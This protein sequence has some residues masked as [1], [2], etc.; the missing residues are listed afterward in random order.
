[1]KTFIL[2]ALVMCSFAANSLLNKAAV[3]VGGMG[4]VGFA[5]VRLIAGA[6]TLSLI[7]LWRDKALRPPRPDYFMIGF[8]SLYMIA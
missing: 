6:L 4:P 2:I 1:M 3:H 5:C 8:F 7:L